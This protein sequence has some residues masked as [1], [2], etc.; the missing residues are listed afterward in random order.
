MCKLNGQ[1]LT[2]ISKTD[3]C[4]VIDCNRESITSLKG[5]RSMC[6]DTLRVENNELKNLTYKDCRGLPNLEMTLANNNSI[7]HVDQEFV[8]GQK[9]MEL[10]FNFLKDFPWDYAET[11]LRLKLAG[12][13]IKCGWAMKQAIERGVI[14]ESGPN[15]LG[16]P[17]KS[18]KEVLEELP[19]EETPP[20]G[21][22]YD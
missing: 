19:P 22:K 13:T 15:C 20:S 9:R 7:H 4:I 10:E 5:V 21:C 12:N 11:G 1:D 3:H 16:A 18:Y 2:D 17:G 6:C 14:I 8:K